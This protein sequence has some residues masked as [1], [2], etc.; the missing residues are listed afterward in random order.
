M[1]IVPKNEIIKY[2]LCE[3]E[4]RYLRDRYDGVIK[5]K[6]PNLSEQASESLACHLIKDGSI[7]K[8]LSPIVSIELLGKKGKDIL[9]NKYH[10]LEVKGT[11]SINGCVTTSKSNFDSFA[12][13]W[14]DFKPFF[15]SDNHIIDVHVIKN[16]KQC[17]TSE[18]YVETLK[19][20]KLSLKSVIDD[21]NKTG[22][23]EYLNFNLKTML[24]L[25]DISKRFWE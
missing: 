13:I 18:R 25:E 24:I 23:Y 4:S 17:I 11:S 10:K 15:N 5:L 12:W 3:K 16:P 1:N 6:T 7:L 14:L 2:L 21:A 9:V 22:N 19:E 8:C 20:N